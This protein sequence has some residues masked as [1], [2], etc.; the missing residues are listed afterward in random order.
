MP[1]ISAEKVYTADDKGEFIVPKE[2][3]PEIQDINLRWGTVKEVTIAGKE[4][5]Q[6]AKTRMYLIEY[7]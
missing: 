5:Q 1:G 7:A 4:P 2:D 3:L 6:S